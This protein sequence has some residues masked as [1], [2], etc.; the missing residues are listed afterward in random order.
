[1]EVNPDHKPRFQNFEC[2]QTPKPGV[3]RAGSD[4][5]RDPTR[6]YM[7]NREIC[8]KPVKPPEDYMNC[9]KTCP[10]HSCKRQSTLKCPDMETGREPM[11]K[12]TA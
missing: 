9:W 5:T 4:L 8:A 6:C 1:M 11:R 2:P 3:A 7:L 10:D 12:H